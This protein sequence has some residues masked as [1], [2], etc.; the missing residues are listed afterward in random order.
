MRFG[1][2]KLET[3]CKDCKHVFAWH[4]E[5]RG[6]KPFCACDSYKAHPMDNVSYIEYVSNQTWYKR[7]ATVLLD[8]PYRFYAWYRDS[9]DLESFIEFKLVL[10]P[11]IFSLALFIFYTLL[12]QAH[13]LDKELKIMKAS[14]INCYSG[15]KLLYSGK[16]TNMEKESGY[17]EIKVENGNVYYCNGMSEEQPK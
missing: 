9:D 3:L 17:V 2:A 5:Y 15:D 14:T 6:C 11:M 8:L 12:T 13:K 10:F 7:I 1:I 4:R 16:V